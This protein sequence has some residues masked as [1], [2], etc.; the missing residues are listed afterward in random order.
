MVSKR[1]AAKPLLKSKTVWA[2]LTVA[3]LVAFVPKL[4][5]AVS[6]NPELSS[7]LIAALNVGLRSLTKKA[8]R[9]F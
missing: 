3:L 5:E 8:S 9:L 1:T 7:L 2:N 6:A 4:R